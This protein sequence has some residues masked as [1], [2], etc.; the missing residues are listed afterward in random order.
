MLRANSKLSP[1]CRYMNSWLFGSSTS[2]KHHDHA[3][4][5]QNESHGHSESHGHDSHHDDHHGDHHDDHGHHHVQLPGMTQS[6]LSTSKADMKYFALNGLTSHKPFLLVSHQWYAHLHNKPLY[7]HA[8]PF[9]G[10]PDFHNI[11]DEAGLFDE[12]YGYEYGDDPFETTGKTH[13]YLLLVSFGMFSLA[14]FF[15]SHFRF[16][17]RNQAE[18]MFH[19]RLTADNIEERIRKIR[20]EDAPIRFPSTSSA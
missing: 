13:Y 15:F 4:E 7:D 12:P 19:Q 11:E 14:H 6:I 3:V 17:N 20:I 2:N 9:S 5:H 10:Y 8:F 1:L 18:V 16:D